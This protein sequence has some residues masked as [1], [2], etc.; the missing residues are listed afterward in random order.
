MYRVALCLTTLLTVPFV[1]VKLPVPTVP[2]TAS[3][4]VTSKLIISL[5]TAAK[6]VSV[7]VLTLGA[8]VSRPWLSLFARLALTTEFPAASVNPVPTRLSATIPLAIPAAGVT[9]TV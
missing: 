5:V 8:S 3:S 1:A 2:T 4:N 7:T 6:V 9:T